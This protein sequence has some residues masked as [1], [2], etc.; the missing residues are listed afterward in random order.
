M[1]FLYF[2]VG[3]ALAI[4]EI[5]LVMQ[6]PKLYELMKK[7]PVFEVTFSLALGVLVGSAMGISSGVTFAV[8]NVF[9]SMV[10]KFIYAM[11]L[12]E[13]CRRTKTAFQH[14]KIQVT[15]TLDDLSDL[16]SSVKLIVSFPAK[17]IKAFLLGLNTFCRYV[18]TGWETVVGLRPHRP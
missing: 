3:I 2:M 8:G 15:K 6:F 17:L 9:G 10:T 1:L 18:R 16:V 5:T 14:R 13:R 4:P 12:I 11:R 7:Y